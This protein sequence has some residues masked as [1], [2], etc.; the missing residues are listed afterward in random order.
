MNIFDSLKQKTHATITNFFGYDAVWVSSESGETYTARVGFKDPSEKEYLAGL[1]DF[2]WEK[3][4]IDY[5]VTSFPGLKLSVDSGRREYVSVIGKGYFS[6]F[7]ITTMSDGDTYIAT[8]QAAIP[9]T[10]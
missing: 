7:Q 8:M 6:I 1:D 2:D 9:P 10:P 5:F 3:P 4:K